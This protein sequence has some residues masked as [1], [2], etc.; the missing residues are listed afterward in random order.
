MDILPRI[1]NTYSKYDA[2]ILEFTQGPGETVY[3]PGGWWHAVINLEDSIAITQVSI[4]MEC[5]YIY[6]GGVYMEGVY[7]EGIRHIIEL[8]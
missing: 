3:V 6:G 2:H 7:M 8:L 1:R 4:Y 5:E